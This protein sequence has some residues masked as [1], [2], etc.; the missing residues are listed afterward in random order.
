MTEVSLE[1]GPRYQ[2]LLRR[3]LLRILASLVA[4]SKENRFS[5]SGRFPSLRRQVE[6][7]SE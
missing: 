2:I 4:E 6:R 1:Y 5:Q 7:C 3:R